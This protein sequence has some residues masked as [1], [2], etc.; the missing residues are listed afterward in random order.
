[1]SRSPN[2]PIH[3]E[4]TALYRV[5]KLHRWDLS[6][7]RRLPTDQQPAA[8]AKCIDGG[9][10]PLDVPYSKTWELIRANVLQ[11]NRDTYYDGR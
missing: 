1:M 7:I 6:W 4:V 8:A 3:P 5:G 2:Q 10:A 9:K 11:S